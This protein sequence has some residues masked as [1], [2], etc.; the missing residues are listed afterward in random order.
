MADVVELRVHGVGGTS[1]EGMLGEGSSAAVIRV[2]GSNK[3]G[4]YARLRQPSVEGYSWGKLTSGKRA[5]VFWLFLLPFTILNA[6]G[7]S[8]PPMSKGRERVWRVAQFAV[9]LVGLSLTI[10]YAFGAFSLVVKRVFYQWRLGGLIENGSLALWLGFAATFLLGVVVY[11][12]SRD[13][14]KKFEGVMGD[15]PD[16]SSDGIRETLVNDRGL[17]DL[18]FWRR[19]RFAHRHLRLHMGVA[20]VA[21]V[22]VTLRAQLE[23]DRTLG[24]QGPFIWLG[25]VQGALLTAVLIASW[26]GFQGQGGIEDQGRLRSFRPFALA[27]L[28]VGLTGGILAGLATVLDK[29]LD[30]QGG[31]PELNLNLPFGLSALALIIGV[32][33][34]LGV[35]LWRARSVLRRT[36]HEP[37]R[38]EEATA[39]AAP[40]GLSSFTRLKIFR[41]LSDFGRHIDIALVCATVVFMVSGTGVLAAMLFSGS[42]AASGPEAAIVETVG[43]EEAAQQDAVEAVSERA[44][45]GVELGRL[46]FL[47]R[48]ASVVTAVG[49]WVVLTLGSR[50]VLYLRKGNKNLALRRNV[51]M[52][53][54]VFSFFP[55]R[56]HPLAVRPYSERAVPELQAR[57]EHHIAEGDY[58]IFSTHSQGTVLGYAALWQLR[59]QDRRKVAFM[60]YGSPLSQLHA[61][62][63][64]RLFSSSDYKELKDSLYE[65]SVSGIEA[66]DWCN[67]Y[68]L[69]DYIGKEVRFEARAKGAPPL[70]D[71]SNIIVSDPC[72]DAVSRDSETKEWPGYPD[73]VRL[74]FDAMALHSYYPSELRLKNHVSKLREAMSGAEPKVVR[75][76]AEAVKQD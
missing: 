24:L 12:F 75:L 33:V 71:A 47:G 5:Q 46:A 59:P 73:P 39:G 55:R 56:F 69:S 43:G 62:Y 14:Q 28:A 58:V 65:G 51:G 27:S 52:L 35:L 70:E 20:F 32:A 18:E 38:E 50:I 42:G 9:A 60:T 25:L 40:K 21:L 64:P 19:Q 7:W 34:T 36:R 29:V 49:A 16:P 8:L 31:G 41:S 76:H 37:P 68:R 61:R 45:F 57:I 66:T 63:F 48:V 2:A 72:E 17:D 11:R 13:R 1:P 4:F 15:Y 26:T 53:W 3:D 22:S 44:P 30:V 6:A 67:F 23:S 54:D 74:P 10:A